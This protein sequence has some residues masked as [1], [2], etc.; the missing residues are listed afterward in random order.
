MTFNTMLHLGRGIFGSDFGTTA[1]TIRNKKINNYNARF[2][3]L[4]NQQGSVDKI[5]KKEEWFFENKGLFINK[6]FSCQ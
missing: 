1:F 3:R 5:S 2:N 6:N 4:F